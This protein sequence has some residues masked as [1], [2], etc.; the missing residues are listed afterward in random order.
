M[1][2]AIDALAVIEMGSVII[3]SRMFIPSPLAGPVRRSAWNV[4]GPGVAA[5]LAG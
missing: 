5:L 3:R 1:A 4:A 2:S